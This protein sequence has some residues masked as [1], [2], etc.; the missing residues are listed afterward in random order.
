MLLVVAHTHTHTNGTR[1]RVCIFVQLSWCFTILCTL[2]TNT[3]FHYNEAVPRLVFYLL[4]RCTEM[5]IPFCSSSCLS[6]LCTS[7]C[8]CIVCI[9]L[10]RNK[11]CSNFFFS[12]SN[13]RV[14]DEEELITFV[15]V[16]YQVMVYHLIRLDV[17]CVCVLL[18]RRQTTQFSQGK[19]YES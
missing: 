9:I 2:L 19:V 12:L 3:V 11:S 7:L 13:E 15:W 6:G 10:I 18:V 16:A 5:L 17:K 1:E 8:R 4:V 14:S